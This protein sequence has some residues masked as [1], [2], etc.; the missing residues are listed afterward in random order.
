MFYGIILG[1]VT[2]L[3]QSLSYLASGYFIR[4]HDSAL[5]LLITS[6]VAMGIISVALMPFFWNMEMLILPGRIWWCLGIW[7]LMFMLGQAGF[8]ISQKLIEP[9]RLASL[10]G[11]KI[12]VLSLI[13]ILFVH[14]WL[15]FLQIIGVILSVSA[16]FAMNWSGGRKFELKSLI[17][18]AVT[19]VCYSLTD[20][21]ETTMVLLCDQGNIVRAGISVTLLC[22]TVLGICSLPLLVKTGW[23]IKMQ[24]HA[25]PFSL[26]WLGSQMTLLIC[27][28]MIG[29]VFGNVIQSS[30]GLFSV[31]FGVVVCR[32]GFDVMEKSASGKLWLRR[33]LAA[34]LMIGGIAC[35]SF[36]KIIAGIS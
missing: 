22:Y 18:L 21:S 29:P 12:V 4:K 30:R 25:L 8:F 15:N 3:M 16:A 32:L 26:L 10:L 34:L 23:N 19:L 9:S 17:P 11:L 36:G 33:V 13:W 35:F 20:I 31:I 28:G 27:F 2:A 14:Q 5:K 24:C 6:H 1:I 7:I